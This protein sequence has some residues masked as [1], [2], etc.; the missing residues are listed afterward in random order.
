MKHVVLYDL[1]GDEE[2]YI[3]RIGRSGRVGNAG[4]SVAFYDLSEPSDRQW[5]PSLVKVC[6]G[7]PYFT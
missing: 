6:I 3:H 2:Q 1:Y 4:H 5:A 7:E